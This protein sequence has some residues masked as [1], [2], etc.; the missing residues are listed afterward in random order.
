LPGIA[1]Q[2]LTKAEEEEEALAAPAEAAA[3]PAEALAALAEATAAVAA[4]ALAT[5]KSPKS[6]ILGSRVGT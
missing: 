2:L 6:S 4:R 5:S 1:S 3:A